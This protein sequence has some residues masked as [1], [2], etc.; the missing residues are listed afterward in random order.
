MQ[1]L[2]GK[3][4]WRGDLAVGGAWGMSGSSVIITPITPVSGNQEDRTVQNQQHHPF[5]FLREHNVNLSSRHV[6]G[7]KLY[8]LYWNWMLSWHFLCLQ[9]QAPGIAVRIGLLSLSLSFSLSLSSR[10]GSK[11][12]LNKTLTKG[13]VSRDT[14]EKSAK[15][16]QN[17]ENLP[18][19]LLHMEPKQG[20]ARDPHSQ[21]V[22]FPKIFT[23]HPPHLSTL[24]PCAFLHP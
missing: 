11:P 3:R 4:D 1:W 9:P 6:W 23:N 12:S 22:Y 19:Y 15:P 5:T 13:P 2:G 7:I 17:I 18:N 20:Y 8:W 10:H 24:K 16:G 14:S 21:S